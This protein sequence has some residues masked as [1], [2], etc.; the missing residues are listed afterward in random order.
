MVVDVGG[1]E[2]VGFGEYEGGVVVYF[3][4]VVVVV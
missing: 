3:L 4:E 1:F 2:G